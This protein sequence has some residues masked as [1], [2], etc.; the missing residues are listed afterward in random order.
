MK[1]GIGCGVG[2]A[3]RAMA[4][5]VL[6]L[7]P[8]FFGDAQARAPKVSD[9]E[10]LDCHSGGTLEPRSIRGETVS[11]D[12]NPTTLNASAHAKLACVEC[13]TGFDPEATPH[14]PEA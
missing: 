4:I 7:F 1:I 5:A 11:L 8:L 12:V 6:A 14:R 2:T 3:R 10:C 13:H 9:E